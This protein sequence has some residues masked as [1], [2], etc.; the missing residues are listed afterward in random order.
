MLRS[1]LCS[2]Q[3]LDYILTSPDPKCLVVTSASPSA[4]AA[5]P[6]LY[7]LWKEGG[8]TYP[9]PTIISTAPVRKVRMSE[10]P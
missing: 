1:S 6:L 2:S 5:L 7:R 10:N 8:K 3:L 4:S 9:F